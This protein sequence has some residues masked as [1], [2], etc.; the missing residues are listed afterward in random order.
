MVAAHNLAV[1]DGV[2]A[3]TE[4]YFSTIE[5]L[6]KIAPKASEPESA[7]SQASQPVSRRSAPPAAPVSRSG[8]GADI[9]RVG[10][11]TREEVEMA[12]MMGMT[13]EEYYKHKQQLKKEGRM[14]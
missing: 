13:K 7:M 9:S 11:L 2:P 1:A 10:R 3:D 6:L 12:D 14:N 5:G 8:N 4:E